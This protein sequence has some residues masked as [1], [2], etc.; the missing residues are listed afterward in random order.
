MK[1]V[2][3]FDLVCGSVKWNQ[4]FESEEELLQVMMTCKADPDKYS[5]FSLVK[6][7]EYIHSFQRQYKVKGALSPKQM[8]QLKRLA[9]SIYMHVHDIH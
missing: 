4:M 1:K 3:H 5:L 6:G 8:T 9:K 2:S 7:Y